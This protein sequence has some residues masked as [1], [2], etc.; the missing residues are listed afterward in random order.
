MRASRL[1]GAD[2]LF[3]LLLAVAEHDHVIGIPDR[4]RGSAPG[5]SG[6]EAGGLVADPGG[7]LQ[8]VQRDVQQAR[9]DRT[10]LCAVPSWR[11][12]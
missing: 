10:A 7:L 8:P 5:V 9:A 6:T 2:H 3:G 4:D 12:W 1:A 11:A